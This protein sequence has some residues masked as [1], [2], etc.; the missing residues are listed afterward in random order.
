MKNLFQINR[1]EKFVHAALMHALLT[2]KTTVNEV[3]RL[4]S[5]ALKSPTEKFVDNTN[6]FLDVLDTIV[7]RYIVDGT[8]DELPEDDSEFLFERISY[9]NNKNHKMVS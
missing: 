3:T 1:S 5:A 4:A 2:G 6:A 9:Y 8:E 7:D